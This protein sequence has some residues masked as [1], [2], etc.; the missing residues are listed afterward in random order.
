VVE[1][2]HGYPGGPGDIINGLDPVGAE[3][4][5]GMP[6]FIAVAP[7]GRGPAVADSWFAD[8]ARQRVGTAV[9]DDLVAFVTGHFRTNGQWSVGGLSAG[10]YGAAYLGARNPRQYQAVCSLSGVFIPDSPAFAGTSRASLLAG[11]PMSHATPF[12]PRTLLVVGAS[13]RMSL[14]ETYQYAVRLG[15][16]GEP[17]Q[18][19]V[20]RGGHDWDLWRNALPACLRYMLGAP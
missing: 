7:D 17:H 20:V 5:P 2:L 6:P 10:G 19:L 12:G 3:E 11:S 4:L 18:V 13:D 8:T 14:R 15:Q 9:S 16:A 1:L